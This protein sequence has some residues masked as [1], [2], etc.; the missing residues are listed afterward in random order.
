[1]LLGLALL[2]LFGCPSVDWSESY[3][4]DQQSP[5]DLY[6]LY[7][8][9]AARPEGMTVLRDSLDL[10]R[11]D[12]ATASNYVFIG[13]WPF[14]R[15]RAVTGLLDYVERG[16]TVFL[17]ATEIPEDLAYHLFGDAC[18]Y[19][20]FEDYA[21]Y[22][23]ERFPL[24]MVDSVTTYRYPA[25]DSFH[26]VNIRFW[27]PTPTALHVVSDRL[28]CNETLDNQVLGVLH[29]SG[30]N[31]VR[32]GWGRGNFY[33]HSNPVFFTNWFL[34][35]STAYRYPE[36]MLSVIAEGPIYWD[37][38]HRRY[39]RD[40]NSVGGQGATPRNY[41]GGR[42]LL[43]GNRTLLYVL[44]RRELAFAWYTLLA[45]AIL[46]VVFRGKRRQRIIPIIPPR[47]NGSRRFIDTIGRLLYQKGNHAALARREL[48][49]LRLH[50]NHRFGVKWAEGDPPPADLASRCGLPPEVVERAL[51]QIRVVSSG[52]ALHDGDLLRFYRAIEPLYG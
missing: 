40:P 46:F 7:E 11:L 32:F 18:Y 31:F 45:G 13:H 15:E 33:F 37:E 3:R 2:T 22:G 23:N 4:Y 10:E 16:N 28:L 48:A 9:L 8:L 35:D 43:N 50:L 5:F 6:T 26:L 17:A 49:F 42:N 21:G 12:T 24:V 14:Y 41:T 20:E 25:G 51:L 1:M 52:K 39:R 34:V 30:I 19:E 38:Y 47:E 44:E 36:A 29:T 27:K